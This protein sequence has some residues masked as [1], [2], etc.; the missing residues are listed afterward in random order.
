MD[1]IIYLLKSF[2]SIF[3]KSN[4]LRTPKLCNHVVH[5]ICALY[6]TSQVILALC[7][8]TISKSNDLDLRQGSEYQF[9]LKKLK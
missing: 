8:Q 9:F 1:F 2:I 5:T 6:K 3:G 7:E 4:S